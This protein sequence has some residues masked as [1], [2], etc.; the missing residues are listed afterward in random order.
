MQFLLMSQVPE[1]PVL[2]RE[3]HLLHVLRLLHLAPHTLCRVSTAAALSNRVHSVWA[4]MKSSATLSNTVHIQ[5]QTT[6]AL[7]NTL[8]VQ[9]KR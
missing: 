1:R 2:V 4:Q 9:M 7:G 6:A 8:R 5:L 3:G